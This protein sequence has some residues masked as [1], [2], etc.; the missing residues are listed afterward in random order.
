MSL[1]DRT[2]LARD[3]RCIHENKVLI[4]LTDVSG[5]LQVEGFAFGQA[6]THRQRNLRSVAGV[7]DIEFSA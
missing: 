5:G 3:Q 7:L 4:G 2:V 6:A 1:N